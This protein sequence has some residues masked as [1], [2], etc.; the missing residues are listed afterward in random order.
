MRIGY[1]G[2]EGTF[3]HEAASLWQK[4]KYQREGE[5]VIFSSF[6]KLIEAV[7]REVEE[8]VVPIENMLEGGINSSL[9][10]IIFGKDKLKIKGEIII[11]IQLN[12]IGERELKLEEIEKVV[13]KKEALSQCLK[14]IEKNLPQAKLEFSLSTAEAIKN[15]SGKTVAVGSLFA[16][17]LYG[18]KVIA[19]AIQEHPDNAT[20]F[21]VLS[22]QDSLFPTGQ[23]K[24]S[25][26]FQVPN[27]PGSLK[28]ALE[29][30][31]VLEINLTKISSRPSKRRLG[32]YIFWIDLE[33][34]RKEKDVSLALNLLK[35]KA[36]FFKNLGSYPK[37]KK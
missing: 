29:I 25:I 16:A 5:M 17:S 10:P 26:I 37:A 1:L 31:A 11:P 23:D 2:P 18:K 19:Q 22:S 7:S 32:E 28:E 12:L 36:T 30:F 21:I 15:V 24:T 9:D 35:K 14:W 34:H 8:G 13:S 20:R 27:Q 4:E 6:S 33:G 3:S